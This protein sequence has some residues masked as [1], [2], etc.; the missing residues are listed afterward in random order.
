MRGQAQNKGS[1]VQAQVDAEAFDYTSK[2]TTSPIPR[3]RI[4]LLR[5]DCAGTG[6]MS[7]TRQSKARPE[8]LLRTGN[9]N[10]LTTYSAP[11]A[12]SRGLPRR[13][14]YEGQ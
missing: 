13:G 6:H 1:P 7:N 9:G 8:S 14:G 12:P 4:P 3:S 11:Q 5:T 10:Q 2:F